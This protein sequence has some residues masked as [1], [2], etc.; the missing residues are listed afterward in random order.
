MSMSEPLIRVRPIEQD[1][2][3]QLRDW[4]NAPE[5]R[6]RSREYRLLNMVNQLDWFEKMSRD[7]NQFMVM[8]E[9]GPINPEKPSD[10][11]SW[12]AVGVM[13]L[14]YIDWVARHGEL[15]IYIGPADLRG[16][17]LGVAMVQE[18]CRIGFEEL[19]LHRIWL[20][21]YLEANPMGIRLFE[22]CGFKE[23]GRLREHNYAHKIYGT[24]MIMG[25]LR[26]E[27][28]HMGTSEG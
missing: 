7:P 26:S 13:G 23:E 3:P 10:E 22:K 5:I 16:K 9:I 12:I 21:C 8:V 28:A 19:N 24:S 11:T 17:G 15:S 18:L 1:D 27:W 14:C 6:G 20:E 2:L 4:R 25:L